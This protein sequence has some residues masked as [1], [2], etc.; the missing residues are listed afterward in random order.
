MRE[1]V[2]ASE[3]AIAT[4]VTA[5]GVIMYTGGKFAVPALI[6]SMGPRQFTDVAC[7]ASAAAYLLWAA[8]P[9]GSTLA[10]WAGLLLLYPGI[11]AN[12]SAALKAMA[13]D[14]AVAKAGNTHVEK[15]GPLEPIECTIFADGTA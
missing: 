9:T 15:L 4:I 10:V 5:Y 1:N 2:G 11:N 12:S 14:V 7:L 3:S 8:V 6:K 13:T